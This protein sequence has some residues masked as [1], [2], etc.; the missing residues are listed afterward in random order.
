MRK[1]L[2]LVLTALGGGA[3]Y[4]AEVTEVATG[5]G[6]DEP[7]TWRWQV[8]SILAVRAMPRR[9]RSRLSGPSTPTRSINVTSAI[10]LL[11][12]Q[13]RGATPHSSLVLSE[14]RRTHRERRGFARAP[15]C[16]RNCS[17]RRRRPPDW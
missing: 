14:R 13:K 1:S 17:R 10:R 12:V 7:S 4:A 6:M 8:S 2:I 3:S 5:P 16:V 15:I 11:G 9:G